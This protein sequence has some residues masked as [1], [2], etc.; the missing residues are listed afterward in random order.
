MNA[1][2]LLA[3]LGLILLSNAAALAGVWYNRQGEPESRVRLSERELQRDWDGPRR[4]NSGLKLRL[5]WRM[6]HQDS[7]AQDQHCHSGGGLSAAQ[8]QAL[9]LPSKGPVP[10]Q[11]TRQ[12]WVVLELDGP[13][14]QHSLQQAEQRL[15]KATARLQEL[16]D[17]KELQQQENA[18][19]VALE[20][21]RSQQSRLFLVDV[22]LTPEA[23]RQ[24]YPQ[25]SQYMVLPGKVRVWRS[26]YNAEDT[27]LSGSV[28]LD[29][30]SISVP[31]T[32]R[33]EL[34]ERAPYSYGN[35]TAPFNVEISIGQR[36]EPWLSNVW[37]PENPPSARDDRAAPR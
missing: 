25:H 18:A 37:L 27:R 22:G 29:N 4:E 8:L 9:G 21:E 6:P 15:R 31:H 16:P 1:R 33:Q 35:A 23:L 10:R 34:A 13:A 3:G 30:T 5:N 12:A 24:R 14:Y 19:Q 17:D 36:F 20:N 11:D 32:W 28:V 26:C 7:P 2:L